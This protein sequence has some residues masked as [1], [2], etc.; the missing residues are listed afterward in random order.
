MR[1]VRAKMRSLL[2][3]CVVPGALALQL[4]A[5]VASRCCSPPLTTNHAVPTRASNV[6]MIAT[7][8]PTLLRCVIGLGVIGAWVK[9]AWEKET[10]ADRIYGKVHWFEPTDLNEDGCTLI[11]EEEG[12]CQQPT[13]ECTNTNAQSASAHKSAHAQEEGACMSKHTRP[14]A[15][16]GRAVL[17]SRPIHA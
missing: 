13:G 10:D 1:E 7:F 2:F 12:V 17:P 11:G 16:L 8:P 5:H 4:P 3:L 6:E 14:H 15:R 9:N